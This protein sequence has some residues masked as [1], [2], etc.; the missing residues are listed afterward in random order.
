MSSTQTAAADP[1][2]V[3]GLTNSRSKADNIELLER[4]LLSLKAELNAGTPIDPK[5]ITEVEEGLN[6]LKNEG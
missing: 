3:Y 4:T 2:E 5:M 6:K 1:Y